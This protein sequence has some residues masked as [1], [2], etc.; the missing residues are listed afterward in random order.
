M[1]KFKFL[2]LF[3]LLFIGVECKIGA[4]EAMIFGNAAEYKGSDIIFYTYS[5]YITETEYEVGRCKVERDGKFNAK[6]KV[7]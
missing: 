3:L 5:D 2:L 6:L 1:A 4:Q 7:L